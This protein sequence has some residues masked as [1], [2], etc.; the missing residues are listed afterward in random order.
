MSIAK[1]L[2]RWVFNVIAVVSVLLFLGA[3]LL[4]MQPLV[5]TY[6]RATWADWKPGSTSYSGR[7]AWFTVEHGYIDVGWERVGNVDP[8]Q[9]TINNDAD[10]RDVERYRRGFALEPATYA[11][12][13]VSL[14]EF[15]FG[16]FKFDQGRNGIGVRVIAVIPVWSV[17][18]VAAIFPG[19]WAGLWIRRRQHQRRSRMGFC[20]KCGYDLRATPLRCPECGTVP[21]KPA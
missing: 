16:D 7:T 21:E 11:N 18:V 6:N 2:G 20:A 12:S 19:A 10:V 15:I 9:F 8:R 17:V 1:R 14:F 4:A 3:V 5:T 13:H